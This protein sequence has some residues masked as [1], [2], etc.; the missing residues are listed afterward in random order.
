MEGFIVT[1]KFLGCLILL[2]AF[3]HLIGL[4]LR[5]DKFHPDNP[6]TKNAASQEGNN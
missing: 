6:E 5:L 3:G 4:L 2:F 1:V